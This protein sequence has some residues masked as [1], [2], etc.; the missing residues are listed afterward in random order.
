MVEPTKIPPGKAPE[1]V[2]ITREE[3]ERRVSAMKPFVPSLLKQFETGD[4]DRD[5]GTDCIAGVCPV[6]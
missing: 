2:T 5:L 1:M 6:R 3:Y 4:D